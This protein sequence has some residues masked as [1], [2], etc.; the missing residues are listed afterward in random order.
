MLP[1]DGD[2]AALLADNN[3]RYIFGL[4]I[5]VG[6]FVIIGLLGANYDSPKYYINKND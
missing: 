6:A 1:P 2:S 3:W 5:I 4:P